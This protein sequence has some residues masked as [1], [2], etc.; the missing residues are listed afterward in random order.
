MNDLRVGKIK[1]RAAKTVDKDGKEGFFIA[2]E[3]W[4]TLRTLIA[5]SVKAP[6]QR[7]PRK[8]SLMPGMK[9]AFKEMRDDLLGIKPLPSYK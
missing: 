1:V 8:K 6:H 4:A 5:N 3:D 7:T 2:K 9:Q